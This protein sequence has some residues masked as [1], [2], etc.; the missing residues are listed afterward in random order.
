[1]EKKTAGRATLHLFIPPRWA[2]TITGCV[3]FMT[4]GGRTGRATTYPSRRT[5]GLPMKLYAHCLCPPVTCLPPSAEATFNTVVMPPGGADAVLPPVPQ[6]L[7][8]QTPYFMDTGL[9]MDTTTAGTLFRRGCGC[10]SPRAGRFPTTVQRVAHLVGSA[11]ALRMTGLFPPP[12]THAPH[13]PWTRRG[14][15]PRYLRLQ[16]GAFHTTH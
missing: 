15:T 6:L 4:V 3:N 7:R 8:G 5:G 2:P 11:T 12:H 14:P 10:G 1:V 16:D 13:R 9:R